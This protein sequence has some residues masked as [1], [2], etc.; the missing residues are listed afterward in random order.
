MLQTDIRGEGR[1]RTRISRATLKNQKEFQLNICHSASASLIPLE[2][3]I[4][5]Y[6][7]FHANLHQFSHKPEAATKGVLCKKV[8]KIHRPPGLQLY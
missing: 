1:S 5:I 8:L 6:N 7:D 4:I 3:A 2:D